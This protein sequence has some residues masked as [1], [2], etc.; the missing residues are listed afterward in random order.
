MTRHH[1]VLAHTT[2]P[3]DTP[4]CTPSPHA[5]EGLILSPSADPISHR[6]VQRIQS[7][8]F[9]EM[10]DLL[11][12]NVSL[13]GQAS[14]LRLH[15]NAIPPS[16]QGSPVPYLMDVLFLGI[17]GGPLQGLPDTRHPVILPSPDSGSPK[18]RR[19]RMAGIR[20]LLSPS[21]SDRYIHAMEHATSGP[22]GSH[23]CWVWGDFW[24]VFP[25]LPGTRPF[26][27]PVRPG[28]STA[29]CATASHS[30]AR[31]HAYDFISGAQSLDSTP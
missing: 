30:H 15:P 24:S 6:L 14:H 21:S 22:S 25:H 1:P 29:T 9:V 19:K 17:C 13:H 11:A 18:A 8:E 20:S 16:A 26:G 4:D 5:T 10:R 7:G 28:S 23:P 31:P 12:D 2:C 3:A 27:H